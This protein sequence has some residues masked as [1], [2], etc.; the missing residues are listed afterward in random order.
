ML[1]VV[2]EAY[3]LE[4]DVEAA[5]M[6]FGGGIG[7]CQST[8]GAI[9]G[10]VIAT[11]FHFARMSTHKKEAS[12]KARALSG[13]LYKD[14]AARFGQ[15]DCLSL[16]GYDFSVPGAFEAH[17]QRDKDLGHRFCNPF[18]EHAVRFLV[19]AKREV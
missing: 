19:E 12:L 11:G 15:T 16:T 17:R 3:E 6:G 18:V 14:F 1:H 13:K 4:T 8:C 9:T 10:G 7:S 2:Q 5:S